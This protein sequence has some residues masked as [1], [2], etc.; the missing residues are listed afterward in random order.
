[1]FELGGRHGG[2]FARYGRSVHGRKVLSGG[3]GSV[4]ETGPCLVLV[5]TRLHN[6]RFCV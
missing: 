2:E 5:T 6:V 4:A 1:M 3:G